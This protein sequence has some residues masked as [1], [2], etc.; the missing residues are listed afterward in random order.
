MEWLSRSG[1]LPLSLK[2]HSSSKTFSPRTSLGVRALSECLNKL[3]PRWQT[4][5]LTLPRDCLSLFQGTYG[6]PSIL[7][8]LRLETKRLSEGDSGF[9]M[10]NAS[11]RELRLCGD[12]SFNSIAIG[13]N[14]LT[15]IQVFRIGLKECVE[16]AKHAQ[17]LE[18]F[19]IVGTKQPDEDDSSFSGKVVTLPCLRRLRIC[20]RIGVSPLLTCISC[21]ALETLTFEN[22]QYGRLG[23]ATL[24][25]LIHSSCHLQQLFFLETPINDSDMI[26]LLKG[27]PSLRH[28]HVSPCFWVWKEENLLE[29][30]TETV[31]PDENVEEGQFLPLLTSF[32]YLI[33]RPWHWT[34]NKLFA[35]VEKLFGMRQRPLK[36]IQL[37]IK[38]WSANDAPLSY[39]DV[40]IL[41]HIHNLWEAG[42][43]LAIFT[44]IEDVDIIK[45][46]RNYHHSKQSQTSSESIIQRS[47]GHKDLALL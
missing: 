45:T 6:T 44:E 19:A 31:I 1:N 25:F 47:S 8:S 12:F 26:S 33:N 9:E 7:Q 5:D 13:F 41:D 23:L 2:V 43:K 18:S 10:A 28:L 21:P 36:F 14:R 29:R 15:H 17:L 42:M 3:S 16:M 32:T 37:Y 11:P 34:W 40:D 30:L 27:I 38:G 24:S 35:E 20:D 22:V 46:S 4:L 39:I